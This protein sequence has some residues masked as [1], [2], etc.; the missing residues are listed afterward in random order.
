[1]VN[2]LSEWLQL[3]IWR[4]GKEHYMRFIDGEAVAPLKAA[5]QIKDKRGTEVTFLPDR[6]IF[7]STDFDFARIEHR[8]R[9]FAIHQLVVRFKHSHAV[10]AGHFCEC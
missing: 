9:E 4:K 8:L 10:C 5:R 3:R 6:N 2:A 7:A 1:M